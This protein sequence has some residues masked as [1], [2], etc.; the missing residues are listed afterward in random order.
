MGW[1][2]YKHFQRG[3]ASSYGYP[4]LKYIFYAW[5]TSWAVATC[6]EA[7]HVQT[8]N[9]KKQPER[10]RG[11]WDC[12]FNCD[13]H[14]A[15]WRRNSSRALGTEGP[16]CL[17]PMAGNGYV[18]ASFCWYSR[19]FNTYRRTDTYVNAYT[20]T[21]P[22]T[23]IRSYIYTYIHIYMY[24]YLHIY[25]YTYTHIYISRNCTPDLN[26][27]QRSSRRIGIG[28]TGFVIL[29]TPSW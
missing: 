20:Y 29:W 25:I 12:C 2:C 9:M 5:Y 18:K 14:G 27:N 6:I 8:K 26:I 19:C 22:P 15:I 13:V 24:S 16:W 11:I 23:H 4:C 10:D 21:C 28:R 7:S 1:E 17:G 3:R